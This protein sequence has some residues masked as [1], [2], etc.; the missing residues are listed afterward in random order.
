VPAGHEEMF[1]EPHVQ[2]L[3]EQLRER[4]DTGIRPLAAAAAR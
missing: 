2:L 3:A 1:H 4:L